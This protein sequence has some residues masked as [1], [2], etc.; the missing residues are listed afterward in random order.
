MARG[1]SVTTSSSERKLT[2]AQA[3]LMPSKSISRS[4]IFS[5]TSAFSVELGPRNSRFKYSSLYCPPFSRVDSEYTRNCLASGM[6]PMISAQRLA[7]TL[8]RG[9]GSLRPSGGTTSTWTNPWEGLYP[10]PGY[11]APET[12]EVLRTKGSPVPGSTNSSLS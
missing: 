6:G 7:I 2:S 1:F 12:R 8:L 9:P 4:R 10:L 3:V 5:A 11:E